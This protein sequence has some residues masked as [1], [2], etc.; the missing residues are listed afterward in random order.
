MERA[1][2]RIVH[3]CVRIDV[4]VTIL[5]DDLRLTLGEWVNVIGYV[6]ESPSRPNESIVKAIM[7]WP[8]TPSFNLAQYEHA[9]S[10]RMQ[11]SV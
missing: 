8:V 4:D 9:V 7:V 6:E 3:A 1:I 10:V 5:V 11:S 2:A